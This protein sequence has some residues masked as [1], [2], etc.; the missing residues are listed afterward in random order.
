MPKITI[1]SSLKLLKIN[2]TPPFYMRGYSSTNSIRYKRESS[3]PF[4]ST[5]VQGVQSPQCETVHLCDKFSSPI[6]GPPINRL[7]FLF[8]NL[9][10]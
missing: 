7:N 1:V 5:L 8:W 3:N 2:R 4:I 6:N 10:L 9:A